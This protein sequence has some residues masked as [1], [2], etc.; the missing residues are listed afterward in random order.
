MKIGIVGLPM[1]AKQLKNRLN[2]FYPEHQFYHFDTY[3][4]KWDQVR[5]LLKAPFLDAVFS[6]NGSVTKSKVFETTLKLNK[7][8][9]LN[10]SGTDVLKSLDAY[11]A[12][13]FN[14][15]LIDKSIHVCQG[16]WIKE[17]LTEMGIDAGLIQF[18]YYET[19]PDLPLPP[20]FKV[21]VR[22]GKNREEFYGIKETIELA[23]LLPNLTFT[24]VGIGG[25]EGCDLKNVEFIEWTNDMDAVYQ[26]H[27]VAFRFPFHDG[28]SP[29]IMESL[30]KG[31]YCFY[32]YN[33]GGVNPVLSIEQTAQEIAALAKQFHEGE[34]GRNERGLQHIKENHQKEEVLKSLFKVIVGQ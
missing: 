29:F 7:R 14:Q 3:Y 11:R 28:M 1:Y 21:L 16:P 18:Q 9:V 22:I 10:W 2:A 26:D 24:I 5:F 8:L 17:E 31:L 13:Q 19:T 32:K 27:M 4:K 12:G 6:L 15:E 30:S 23:Q 34:L 33:M 20:T 25:Y